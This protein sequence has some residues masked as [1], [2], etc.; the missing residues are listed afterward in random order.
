MSRTWCT[1]AERSKSC[2]P[3]ATHTSS[4]YTKVRSERS[5]WKEKNIYI[6]IYIKKIRHLYILKTHEKK[7]TNP[8][9][10]FPPTHVALVAKLQ[11]CHY[12]DMHMS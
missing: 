6:H 1:S 12:F 3:S 5:V 10:I 8:K 4:L 11:D 7:H 9:C 2:H